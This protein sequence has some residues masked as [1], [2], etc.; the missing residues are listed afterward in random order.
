MTTPYNAPR[1]RGGPLYRAPLAALLGPGIAGCHLGAA[2]RA[3]EEVTA[4][5][6]EKTRYRRAQPIGERGAFQRD[7]GVM[8]TRLRA[9]R[10]ALEDSLAEIWAAV[11]ANED[12]SVAKFA[13]F[14]AA[15]TH[16]F[17]VA[18][19]AAAFAFEY[20]GIG[21]LM[22]DHVLQK[23]RR[24]VMAVGQHV[25]LANENYEFAGRALLGTAEH[26]FNTQPRPK[27]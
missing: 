15:N 16:G 27:S 7:L 6:A 24:D 9:A 14:Q 8:S 23:I 20:A 3:L 18:T 5:A 22:T 10:L 13:A 26:I 2:R 12:I 11:A 21:A 25:S 19:E 1:R 4:I 17:H